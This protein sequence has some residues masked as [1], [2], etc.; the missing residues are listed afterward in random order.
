MGGVVGNPFKAVAKVVKKISKEIG[1]GVKK[2][3]KETSRGVKKIYKEVFDDILGIDDKRFLGIKGGIFGK[4]G[5]TF[6]DTFHDHVDKTIG[7]GIMVAGV[8]LGIYA[9]ASYGLASNAVLA[10]YNAGFTSSFAIYGSY[11]GVLAA[12]YIGTSLFAS[13]L[14][15]GSILAMYPGMNGDVGTYEK[16]EEIRLNYLSDILS[17][18]VFDKMAGGKL[19]AS[20]FAGDIYYEATTPGNLNISVGETMN[21]SAMA[22]ALNFGYIDSTLKNL[23]GDDGFSVV[24]MTS[25]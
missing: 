18:E 5:K 16:Q 15:S 24:N 22:I 23:A 13:S 7:L 11:Y 8:A 20:Q 19:Y 3:V 6:K 2:V 17:G 9:S 12:S 14:V 10:A 4:I 1:R 21:I 25:N